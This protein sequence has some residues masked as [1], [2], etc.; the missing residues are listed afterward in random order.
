MNIEKIDQNNIVYVDKCDELFKNFLESERIYDTNSLK[1][2][3]N[4]FKKDV[5]KDNVLLYVAKVE[6]KVVAFLYG[7]IETSVRQ[8]L[9]VAHL[10]FIY[11]EEKYR[12][13]KIATKLIDYFLQEVK[14]MNI[15]I[16]EVK[17]FKDNKVACNI[18][19]KL[20]FKPLW[21]NYRKM[22]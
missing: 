3:P 4:S 22:L 2:L 13:Q 6:D 1:Y 21:I 11:V 19:E 9:P 15:E 5:S 8:K 18:Y 14:Q 10:T 20:G 16:I 17:A 12:K 7:Y